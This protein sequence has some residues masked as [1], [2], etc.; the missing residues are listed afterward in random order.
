MFSKG[1]SPR[2]LRRWLGEAGDAPTWADL[3]SAVK[4]AMRAGLHREQRGLCCYCHQRVGTSSREHIEH[5]EPRTRENLFDWDNMALACWG[6]NEASVEATCDHH[7]ADQPL[8]V[9]HPHRAPVERHA[10]LRASGRLRAWT[11]EPSLA[12]ELFA[13]LNLDARRL[14]RARRA[15]LEA[16]LPDVKAKGTVRRRA[17]TRRWSERQLGA[18]LRELAEMAT[19][20]AY[21]PLLVGWF[22]RQIRR[23]VG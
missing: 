6:G 4:Q 10:H 23:R 16:L 8:A 13:V 12:A 22:E 7:K 19:P 1:R 18:T 14:Q 20:V 17:R 2:E 11:D 15:A 3:P 9:L 5:V 21:Q